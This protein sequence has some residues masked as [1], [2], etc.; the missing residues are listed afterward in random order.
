MFLPMVNCQY[1]KH[2]P[3]LL[4]DW[5][6]EEVLVVCFTHAHLRREI[7]KRLTRRSPQHK[8]TFMDNREAL[9][10]QFSS[11]L[12]ILDLSTCLLNEKVITDVLTRATTSL[13]CI[14]NKTLDPIISEFKS[15]TQYI[16]NK[17]RSGAKSYSN[18]FIL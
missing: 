9:G 17:T 3:L 7:E 15:Y 2:F 14:V 11:V 16:F 4:T 12:L 8:M 5:Q 10:C 18:K 13:C 1:I 6:N